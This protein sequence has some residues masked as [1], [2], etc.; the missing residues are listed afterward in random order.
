MKARWLFQLLAALVLI[1][2]GTIAMV[3]AD[4]GA[5]HQVLQSFPIALGASGGNINDISNAFCCSGTLGALV[6][7]NGRHY[8]LSNNHV[9]A[10]SGSGV[11]NEAITHPGLI[12]VSCRQGDAQLVAQ[13]AEFA[14]LGSSNVDAA[15]AEIIPGRVDTSGAILD[16]GAPSD[17][18]AA[19]DASALN[20]MVAKSGRTTGLTCAKISSISTNVKVQ[21][22][23]GCNQG[24]K[25]FVVYTNQVVIEGSSFSAGGDSG[26]VIVTTDTTQPI[27]LLFAGS[28]STTIGN[29]ISD[30]TAALGVSFVG[31]ATPDPVACPSKGGGPKPRSKPGTER[32]PAGIERAAQAKEKHAPRLMA[33]PAVLG[34]GVGLSD[35]DPSE[36]VIVIYL[37]LGRAHA[38]IPVEL[39]GV[40]TRIVRTD[41]IR[42]YGWNEAEA[43]SCSTARQ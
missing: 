20:R 4:G 14:P 21:Y 36:T 17:T 33:D 37:E 30:V 42:A 27:A 1:W 32:A 5:N 24:K 9:L 31:T 40:R 8:V 3:L 11:F 41:T 38:Q 12:D 7:K 2:A 29:R 6:T 23:M 18:P 22:Q 28:S 19:V 26:A 16:I 10:R 13:L 34:V 15:I 43:R 25:F 39:D 35:E